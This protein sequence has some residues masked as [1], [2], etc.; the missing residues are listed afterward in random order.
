[1]KAP[2]SAVAVVLLLVC[3]A[4]SAV[5]IGEQDISQVYPWSGS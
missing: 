4:S 3:G 5:E 2:A 1:M